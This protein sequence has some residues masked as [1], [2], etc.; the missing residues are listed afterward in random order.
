[1]KS[2]KRILNTF[3]I[4]LATIILVI[5]FKYINF[6]NL[7]YEIRQV[8][9]DDFWNYGGRGGIFGNA[10]IFIALGVI[11]GLWK[12]SNEEKLTKIGYKTEVEKIKTLYSENLLT[13]NEVESKFSEMLKKHY[14]KETLLK[15]EN[16]N[17]QNDNKK[18]Q[19]IENLDELKNQGVISDFEYKIKKSEIT[20]E[21]VSLPS[22]FEMETVIQNFNFGNDI[23]KYQTDFFNPKIENRSNIDLL[24]IISQPE[25]FNK[26]AVYQ[27]CIEINKRN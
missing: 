8:Y 25:K 20:K 27:A 19:L 12:K 14:S 15:K 10:T 24:K 22:K 23:K 2:K 26:S 6:N 3:L 17:K 1:M 11:I 13:R 5:F 9:N 4:V 7:P 18:T 16:L 21:E